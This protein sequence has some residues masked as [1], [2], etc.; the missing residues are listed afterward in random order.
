MLETCCSIAEFD[1]SEPHKY[2]YSLTRIWNTDAPKMVFILLN[3]SSAGA[4]EGDPTSDFC[5]SFA[6]HQEGVGGVEILNLFARIATKPKELWKL[7]LDGK[8]TNEDL[9]GLKNPDGFKLLIEAY[10]AGQIAHLVVGW[11][12]DIKEESFDEAKK[13]LHLED[14]AE[15]IKL[16]C[17]EKKISK[18]DS[19][20]DQNPYH[21][22]YF[23]YS[24]TKPEA[25]KLVPY[26]YA[27][28]N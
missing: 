25:V 24:R 18:L 27:L 17:L 21:P 5:V 8:E 13:Q 20:R 2:R 14:L 6:R 12:S 16:E 28:G 10:K 22:A 19:F 11:G 3:P 23:V 9:I 26:K 7:I 4:A 15:N 1:D